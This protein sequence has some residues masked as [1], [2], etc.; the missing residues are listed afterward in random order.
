VIEGE[1]VGGLP[2]DSPAAWT[3]PPSCGFTQAYLDLRA[4]EILNLKPAEFDAAA[5]GE[6]ALYRA[7]ARIRMQQASR[8]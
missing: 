2:C 8:D 4:C 3:L 7:Y 6:R 1:P 5:P